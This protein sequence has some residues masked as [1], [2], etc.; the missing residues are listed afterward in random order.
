MFF[1]IM[2][3][4]FKGMFTLFFLCSGTFLIRLSYLETRCISCHTFSERFNFFGFQNW[5]IVP[6]IF[7]EEEHGQSKKWRTWTLWK[8][9]SDAIIITFFIFFSIDDL[10]YCLTVF[11]YREFLIAPWW[12]MTKKVFFYI[13]RYFFPH[14]SNPS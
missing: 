12:K 8:I 3:V 2:M 7:N 10:Y 13:S 1:F 4:Y 6:K 14:T 5:K 9:Y 11:C